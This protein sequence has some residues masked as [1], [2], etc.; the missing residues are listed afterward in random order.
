VEKAKYEIEAITSMKKA[1]PSMANPYPQPYTAEEMKMKTD[2]DMQK[3]A[4]LPD[5]QRR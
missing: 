5:D 4:P 3:T 2:R 1:A